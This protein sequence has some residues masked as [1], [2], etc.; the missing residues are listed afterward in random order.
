MNTKNKQSKNFPNLRF[1]GFEGEWERKKLGEIAE[2]VTGST[3]PTNDSSFYNGDFLFVSPSDIQTHR[4]ISQT[5]TTLTEKG[6]KIGRK[7]RSG[8]SLFVC[9]GSTI[10]K[11]GQVKKEC[12]TNQQI[13]SVISDD[14][15]DDNFIF[16]LLE[17]NSLKIKE[18]SAE[19]AVPII[20]KT[21]FSNFKIIIPNL[22]EQTKIALFLL[23]IDKRITT[24]MK[25]IE[26]LEKLIRGLQEQIFSQKLRFK[27]EN[28]NEFAEWEEKKIGELFKVTRG[29][30]L[31]MNLIT[32]KCNKKMSYPVYSSQTKN[33]GLA[34]YYN[35]FLFENAITWTTD[36]ANA[37]KVHYRKGKFYCTNVCGVLLNEDGYANIC[38]AQIINSISKSY[39]SY[40]GNPKLMN[41]VMSEINILTP[42]LLEQQ[43]IA[44]FLSLINQKF[45]TERQLLSKY[46]NQKK[47]LL[48]NMFI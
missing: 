18:L 15:N 13:N 5:K 19:Q 32:E 17:H 42:S 44:N 7:I 1:L 28:G 41:N 21:T 12:V 26:E 47:F 27:D 6:F 34:G 46:Q 9:I 16:S 8:S 22:P 3:P 31:P 33:N 36:G 38:I 2:I 11:V 48:Q 14:N 43:K 29:K 37:G 25:I 35:E 39:V 23:H 10:G 20:N 40:V 30:V 45:D 24:Q 4:H